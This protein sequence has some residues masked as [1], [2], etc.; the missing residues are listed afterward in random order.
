MTQLAAVFPQLP[1][2][3]HDLATVSP[4]FLPA[5]NQPIPVT[6]T[7]VPAQLAAIVAQVRL[8]APQFAAIP[9]EFVAAARELGTV[10][11]KFPPFGLGEFTSF[12][13]FR[14]GRGIRFGG[15][16][17][18]GAKPAGQGEHESL[19][20]EFHTTLILVSTR[21]AGHPVVGRG[22]RIPMRSTPV[23]PGLQQS[24]SQ[25]VSLWPA[26]A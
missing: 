1:S 3:T 2:I 23:M 13:R 8:V 21:P 6:G 17:C 10:P 7:T 15:R 14:R 11:P 18:K 5:F 19:F 24:R 22:I 12:R 20:Q 25:W 16:H 4:Q 9:S 26:L